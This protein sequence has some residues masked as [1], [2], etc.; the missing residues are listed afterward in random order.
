M[1]RFLS[2]M[3]TETLGCEPIR[4]PLSVALWN[5]VLLVLVGAAPIAWSVLF[6]SPLDRMRAIEVFFLFG[7]ILAG[8]CF[9]QAYLGAWIGGRRAAG[10]IVGLVI[11]FIWGVLIYE[12][13]TA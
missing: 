10:F 1:W 12:A 2:L 11:S 13:V 7:A 9:L 5:S 8:M 4:R 6:R 3:R